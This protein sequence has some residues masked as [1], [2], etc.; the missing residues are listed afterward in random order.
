MPEL[1]RFALVTLSDALESF[2]TQF[3][4]WRFYAAMRTLSDYLG[5]LS[6]VYLD[7]LKDRLYADGATSVSR[8]SAQTV[9]STIL[10]TLVRALAPVLS[11]TCEEVWEFMPESLRDAESV[12]LS[13]W[14]TVDVPAGEGDVLRRVY[15][16]VL[17]SREVVTKAL[18]E[19]RAA[20]AIGKSQEARVVLSAPAADYDVLAQRA[21]AVLAEL[22]IVAEVEVTAADSYGVKIEPASGEKCPRCWNYRELGTNASMPD[23]CVRCAE[24]LSGV[25]E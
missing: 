15:S 9:L 21:G 14:P 3:D 23:L 1:D 20:K 5:E 22:F 25:G 17:A 12:L 10:G 6:S 13:D 11:F 19:A 8:R 18:E 4:E 16:V 24:V 2:T 7:V